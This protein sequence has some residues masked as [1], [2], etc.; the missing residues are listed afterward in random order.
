MPGGVWADPARGQGRP[1]NY[2]AVPPSS[3]DL[4]SSLGR[5]LCITLIPLAEDMHACVQ[6]RCGW[7][8]G[9]DELQHVKVARAVQHHRAALRLARAAVLAVQQRLLQASRRS[10]QA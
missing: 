5:K 3:A 6:Y 9:Q 1:K 10:M 4:E 7:R 2:E 8:T